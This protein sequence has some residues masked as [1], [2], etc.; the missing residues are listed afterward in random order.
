MPLKEGVILISTHLA[1]AVKSTDYKCTTEFVNLEYLTC[2]CYLRQL[3]G[4]LAKTMTEKAAWSLA[5]DKGLDLVVINPAIVLGP[6]QSGRDQA[7]LTY[8]QG[9]SNGMFIKVY[10]QQF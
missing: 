2:F 10:Y 9:T 1:C 3:W 8:L 5:T 6:K 7:I 4:P